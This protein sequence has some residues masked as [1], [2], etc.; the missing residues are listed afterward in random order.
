MTEAEWL[1]CANPQPMLEF[2][3][4]KATIARWGSSR[5]PRRAALFRGHRADAARVSARPSVVAGG[6]RAL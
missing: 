6:R 2:V 3:R 4:R 5:W 1:A